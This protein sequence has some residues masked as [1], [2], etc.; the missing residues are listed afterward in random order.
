MNTNN[1]RPERWTSA[2]AA[3][4]AILPGPR[5]LRRGVEPGGHRDPARVPGDGARDQRLR[6]SGVAP[7]RLDSRRAADG[8]AAAAQDE[9]Q[10][11]DPAL[12]TD[13]NMQKIFRAMQ[14]HGLIVADNGSDMYITG[15]FDTRWNNDILNPAFAT[16]RPATS[17]SSSSA[18]SRR[19]APAAAQARSARIRRPWP[20]GSGATGTVTLTARGA[21]GRRGGDA[22]EH[23]PARSACPRR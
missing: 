19:T 18:G 8:R 1:R 5:P 23:E 22:V 7:R 13:P 21:G 2:D 4:L 15:T 17:R 11:R 12:R 6:V 14:K 16:S 10:R 3:G 9:R 20:A